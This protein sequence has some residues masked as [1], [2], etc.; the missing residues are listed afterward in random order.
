MCSS[1][2]TST[3]QNFN[4]VDL[5]LAQIFHILLFYITLCPQYDVTSNLICNKDLKEPAEN[6]RPLSL[7][8][9]VS[10]VLERCV[11]N[12]LYDHVNNLITPLQLGRNLLYFAKEFDN[13][14]HNVLLSKLKAYGMS[15]QLS[16][17]VR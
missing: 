7:L 3:L 1:C 6:Y 14:D 9:I 2:S 13:V 12:C 16:N 8:P 10:K 5:V 15:G 4:P 11:F 17:L